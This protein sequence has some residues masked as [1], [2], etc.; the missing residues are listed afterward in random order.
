MVSK[1]PPSK[2]SGVFVY[3]FSQGRTLYKV[4]PCKLIP[5][6]INHSSF[7]PSSRATTR[8]PESFC[9]SRWIPNQVGNDGWVGNDGLV[10]NDGWVGNDDVG[11]TR[12]L[13]G[14][15]II[16]LFYVFFENLTLFAQVGYAVGMKNIIQ[17]SIEKGEDGYYTASA[18]DFFIVTQAKSLDELVKNIN[19]ATELYFEDTTPEETMVN[20]NPSLFINYE[21]PTSIYA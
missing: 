12:E 14:D 17:F 3:P 6:P 15:G 13:L 9:C 1:T 11:N 20:R 10:W 21:L 19:E 5:S 16:S 7:R 4:R 8:D 2:E 18:R